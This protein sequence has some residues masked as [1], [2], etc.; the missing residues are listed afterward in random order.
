MSPGMRAPS[1]RARMCMAECVWW[2]EGRC[3][4]WG[5]GLEA[6]LKARAAGRGLEDLTAGPVLSWTTERMLAH[7]DALLKI[8]GA[9]PAAA[10]ISAAP[11][12]SHHAC[13]F[14]PVHGS[15]PSRSAGRWRWFCSSGGGQQ[16]LRLQQPPWEPRRR[17]TRAPG[18]CAAAPCP[19]PAIDSS[20]STARVQGTMRRVRG[21]GLQGRGW[22]SAGSL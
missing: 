9:P 14:A 21:G 5:A 3:V 19:H 22:R 12:M 10:A 17:R 2:R 11:C 8:P 15:R 13:R 6:K 16:H 20:H 1:C 4:G 18:N 7:K